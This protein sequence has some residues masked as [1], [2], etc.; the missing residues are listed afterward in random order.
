MESGAWKRLSKT[1][2][3]NMKRDDL[4][5]LVLK[6]QKEATENSGENGQETEAADIKTLLNDILKE[7][8]KFN[9][10][11]ETVKRELTELR[12]DNRKLNEALM[13]QQRFL[14]VLD[15]DRRANKVI[16][17]GV[18]EGEMVDGVNVMRTDDT[19]VAMI[20]QKI[21][22][23]DEV[24]GVRRLGKKPE[25]QPDRIRPLEVTLKNAA[26]RQD[27]LTNSKKLKDEAQPYKDIGLRKDVHP[28]V[29][30]EWKRLKEAEESE[31]ARNENAG[32]TICIDYKKRVLM[33]DNII[34]DR[35]APKFF[36]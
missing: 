20:L 28:A 23:H 22:Q 19:K 24:A 9:E 6:I 25:D 32:K 18:P 29:R 1:E 15:A 34:I 10:E 26:K 16:V 2:I 17:F 5:D 3:N 4:R 36:L 11:K 13:Q 30:K 7:M 27:I 12:T 14:E 33:V 21:G 8:K 35:F 31:K